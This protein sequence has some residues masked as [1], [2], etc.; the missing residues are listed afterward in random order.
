MKKES[1]YRRYHTCGVFAIAILNTAFGALYVLTKIRQYGSNLGLNLTELILCIL[2]GIFLLMMA[3]MM[4]SA[5]NTIK[6][7]TF[8][9]SK[10]PNIRT[11]TLHLIMVF[12]AF[13]G[14][15]GL[16]MICLAFEVLRT[17]H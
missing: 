11:V 12:A 8:A 9:N 4:L 16:P 3:C 1:M 2:N 14:I 13:T 5:V 7:I 10:D 17:D 15:P 6:R